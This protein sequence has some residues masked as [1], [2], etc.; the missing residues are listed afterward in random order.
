MNAVK[1]RYVIKVVNTT[2]LAPEVRKMVQ[3]FFIYDCG[4]TSAWGSAHW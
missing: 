2:N 3:R 1:S 4:D